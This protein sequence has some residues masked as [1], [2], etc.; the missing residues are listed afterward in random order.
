MSK[1]VLVGKVLYNALQCVAEFFSGKIGT[2]ALRIIHYSMYLSDKEIADM[3]NVVKK[4]EYVLFKDSQLDGRKPI[5]VFPEHVATLVENL[6]YLYKTEK[7]IHL[8]IPAHL[9]NELL[10]VQK[11]FKVPRY[12]DFINRLLIRA[13]PYEIR[14]RAYLD[15]IVLK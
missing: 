15:R 1:Q 2:E 5:S 14:Y 10:E 3:V 4:E 7:N 8:T 9:Q 13:L 11:Q 12:G 6:S